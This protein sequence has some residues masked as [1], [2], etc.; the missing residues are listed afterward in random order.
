MPMNFN[1]EKTIVID[2]KWSNLVKVWEQSQL[3]EGLKSLNLSHSHH[4][5]ETPDFSKAPYL[6]K[7]ILKDC[8][9]LSIIHPSIGDLK[10]IVLLNLKDC[11]SLKHL[12]G[13]V[14]NLKSLKTLYLCGCSKIEKLEEDIG[15]MESLTILDANQTAIAQVPFSLVRLKS[16]KYV[17]LCGYEGVCRD[18]PITFLIFKK[19]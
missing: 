16:I 9:S 3:L 2:L 17:S 1:L 10:H 12:P 15:Q 5:T 14:Y 19:M 8:P 18:G 6:E 11:K 7:L 13:S 4:L